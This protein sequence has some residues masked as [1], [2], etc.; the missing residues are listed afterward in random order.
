MKSVESRRS[1][2][3]S[4]FLI[5]LV[6]GA[7]TGANLW[8]HRDGLRLGYV[9][10]S[11]FGFSFVYPELFDT[12]TWGN[13]NPASN[14]SDFGGGA[15]AKKLWKGVW[16]NV[17][18]IWST[19]VSTPDLEAELDKFYA[20][21]DGWGCKID[22]KDQ[23]LASEKDGHEMLYQTWGFTEES[24]RSGGA[25]FIAA[26]GVWYEPWPPLHSN[27]VYILTYIAFSESTTQQQVLDKF[28]QYLGSFYSD[29]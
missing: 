5:V 11:N 4:V 24:F 26:S 20:S 15:Q 12:Y 23:L 2:L 21:V 25:Q 7:V 3:M 6:V 10:Y 28:E 1:D 17:I 16:Q 8:L 22:S 9:R 14:P 27:R 19:E 18:V 13:P 29:I